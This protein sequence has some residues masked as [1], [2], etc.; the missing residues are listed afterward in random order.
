M[1]P[2]VSRLATSIGLTAASLAAGFVAVATALVAWSALDGQDILARL[3]VVAVG[4]VVAIALGMAIDRAPGWLRRH[5][6]RLR[7]RP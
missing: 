3:L 1:R 2:P 4:A 6:A 5:L 7:E